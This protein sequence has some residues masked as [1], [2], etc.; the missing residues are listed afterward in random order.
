MV[1]SLVCLVAC[2]DLFSPVM[3]ELPRAMQKGGLHTWDAFHRALHRRVGSLRALMVLRHCGS[4]CSIS[5]C[6]IDLSHVL[7]FF[8]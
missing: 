1:R 5:I 4:G 3:G 2:L 6:R 8:A 7:G